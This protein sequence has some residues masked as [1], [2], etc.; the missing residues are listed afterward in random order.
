METPY[1]PKH[2]K[3]PILKPLE[4]NDKLEIVRAK[5]GRRRGTYP[6]GTILRFV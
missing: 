1:L 6:A 3:K 4:E 5:S 2:L